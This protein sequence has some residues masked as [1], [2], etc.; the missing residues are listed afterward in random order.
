M[1]RQLSSKSSRQW[2]LA[3]LG[4][5]L[6]SSPFPA[7]AEQDRVYRIGY[8]L[9][10]SEEAVRTH[11]EGFLK[12]LRERGYIEGENVVIERRFGDFDLERLPLLARELVELEP[13]VIVTASPPGVRAVNEATNQCDSNRHKP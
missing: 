6:L 4:A 7:G 5:A 2:L 8:L 11:T 12:G 3:L 9:P 10:P 13:D 1:L